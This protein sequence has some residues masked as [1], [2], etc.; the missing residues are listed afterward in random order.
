MNGMAGIPGFENNMFGQG[1]SGASNPSVDFSSVLEQ[2][3]TGVGDQL[4]KDRP[5]DISEINPFMDFDT[6]VLTEEQKKMLLEILAKYDPG[7]LSATDKQQMRQELANAGIFPC[8]E[9]AAA[10][11]EAGFK[12]GRFD[13][14]DP[15]GKDRKDKKYR[16]EI[17]RNIMSKL[18][19]MMDRSSITSGMDLGVNDLTGKT[20][21]ID[22]FMGGS[23]AESDD[24]SGFSLGDYM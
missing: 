19:Q 16:E 2:M 12:M 17:K 1:A 21:S 8:R 6:R 3:M 13:L 23:D 14:N 5:R 7:S 20:D 15:L 22:D 11:E 24:S 9:L 10:F 4:P 18:T